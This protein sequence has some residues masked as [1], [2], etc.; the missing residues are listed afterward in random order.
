MVTTAG[1]WAK[2]SFFRPGARQVELVGQFSTGCWARVPMVRDAEGYWVA[3]IRLAPG[4]Y[5]FRYL[6]DGQWFCDYASFGV[7]EGPAGPESI[8]R[9][10]PLR[11]AAP[12]A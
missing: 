7:E 4:L 12:A 2:F 11:Q 6:A 5:R 9:I 3:S 10:P 8:V 1:R